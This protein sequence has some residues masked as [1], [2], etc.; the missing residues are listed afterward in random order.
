MFLL[1]LNKATGQEDIYCTECN[2]FIDEICID[3]CPVYD[4]KEDNNDDQ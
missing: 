4:E 1:Q 3:H 2:R